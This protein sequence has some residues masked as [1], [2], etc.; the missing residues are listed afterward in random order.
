M[1]RD[2]HDDEYDDEGGAER[3]DRRFEGRAVLDVLL[4]RAGALADTEDVVAAFQQAARDGVPAS[5]VIQA[6]WEDEPRFESPAQARQLFGNLLALFELVA[7][8]AAVDLA[9]RAPS[10]K[11]ARAPRPPPFGAEGPDDDFVEA[12]WRYFEDAPKERARLDDAFEHR[13]DALVSWLDAQ[14]LDDDAFALARALLADVH[15]ILVLGDLSLRP[16]GAPRGPPGEALAD[17]ALPGALTRW[18]DEGVFEAEHH[19]EAPLAPE[20]AA[21][22]RALVAQGAAALWAAARR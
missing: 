8:G 19:E 12:A 21:R 9:A 11:R 10:P 1:N 14:G 6:L 15:A 20:A 2:E 5:V 13:Q 18:L 3:L 7:A 17:D 22:V 4:A 16:M